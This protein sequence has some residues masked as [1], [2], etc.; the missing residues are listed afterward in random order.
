MLSPAMLSKRHT[1]AN[2]PAYATGPASYAFEFAGATARA[3]GT[4]VPRST[5]G[6]LQETA[7]RGSQSV[8]SEPG[9]SQAG[10]TSRD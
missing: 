6:L 8:S 9:C 2:M 4:L 3:V 1:A 7:L 5:R 10:L